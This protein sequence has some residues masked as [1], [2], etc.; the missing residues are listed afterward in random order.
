MVCEVLAGRRGRARRI[1]GGAGLGLAIVQAIVVAHGGDVR[2]TSAPE[3]GTTV[4]VAAPE[5]DVEL[6]SPPMAE[7]DPLLDDLRGAR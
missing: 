4:R 7:R 2:L 5:R 3:A 1:G 6:G